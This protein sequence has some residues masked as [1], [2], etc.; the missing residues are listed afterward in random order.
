VAAIA[1]NGWLSRGQAKQRGG[2]ATADVVALHLDPP[3]KFK[4]TVPRPTPE[5]VEEAAAAL[6]WACDLDR[7]SSSDYLFNCRVVAHLGSW[8]HREMGIGCSIVAAYQR[9]QSRL[10]MAEFARRLPSVHIGDVGARFGAKGTKKN[11][12]P[13]TLEVTVIRTYEMNGDFGLTTIVTMQAQVDADHVA[14]L[15]WFASGTVDVEP[16]DRATLI[17]TV[18]RHAESKKTGRPETHLSRCTLVKVEESA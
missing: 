9:E 6:A 17:G 10:K 11:P 5:Q 13:A 2:L 16:G 8:S 15:V 14:D 7:D 1:T 12:A 18:K 4:A 3:P